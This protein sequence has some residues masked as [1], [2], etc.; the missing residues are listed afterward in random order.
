MNEARKSPGC[1][2]LTHASFTQSLEP[3]QMPYPG[4]WLSGFQY[5]NWWEKAWM[6]AGQ[7]VASHLPLEVF[8]L[9]VSL[10]HLHPI[11]VLGQ[12]HIV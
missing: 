10:I 2:A 3:S 5:R 8:H 7:Q 4:K 12:E 1:W 9:P 11:H 6:W